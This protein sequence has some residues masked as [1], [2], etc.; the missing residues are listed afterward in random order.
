M[1][2]KE[3]VIMVDFDGSK[4]VDEI[5]FVYTPLWVRV[6]KMPLGMMNRAYGEAIGN[7][8]GAFMEME[9][10]DDDSAVGQCLRIKVR[11]DIRKPLMRGVTLIAGEGEKERDVWCNMEYEYL[12]DFC[13]IC[14]CLGHVDKLC[15]VKLK[16]GEPKQF[17]AKLRYI[18]EKRWSAHEPVGRGEL[19][20]KGMNVWRP[21]CAGNRS[22]KSGSGSFGSGGISKSDGV[23][24]RKE[25]SGEKDGKS[26]EE[27]DEVT[28]PLKL[29]VCY[30][31][32]E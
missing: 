14:G 22:Y 3:L 16:E 11:F 18:P 12:P 20:Q 27:K 8:V 24:W 9:T 28:S 15:A 17:S 31:G 2:A 26:M 23:S 5:E 29:A 30:Y 13:Y 19:G 4:S 6:L 1:L 32:D 25:V 21:S 10:E 7:Q